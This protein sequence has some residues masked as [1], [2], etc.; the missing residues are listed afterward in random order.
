[1][2]ITKKLLLESQNASP[3][4]VDRPRPK[5]LVN[6]RAISHCIASNRIPSESTS[7]QQE[8]SQLFRDFVWQ[9]K[10]SRSL[11]SQLRREQCT[12]VQARILNIVL[13]GNDLVV[14]A[15][16]DSG[17]T[18]ALLISTIQRHLIEP[19][20]QHGHPSILIIV[21]TRGLALQLEATV[22]EIIGK[23]PWNCQTA[24]GGTNVQIDIQRVRQKCDI[25][26]ATP[27]RLSALLREEGFAQRMRQIRCVIVEEAGKLNRPNQR[28]DLFAI[29]K[30]LPSR[31][32][33]RQTLL[34]A[35][36]IT[37]RFL[38][39]VFLGKEYQHLR[40]SQGYAP[41]H[42]HIQKYLILDS[43]WH[44]PKLA[45]T[46]WD[47]SHA[48]PVNKVIVFFSTART[49]A[50]ASATLSQ[51]D[52]RTPVFELHS[53]TSLAARRRVARE[54]TESRS[55]ILLSSDLT[56][57]GGFEFPGITSVI[58]VG[59][60]ESVSEYLQRFRHATH[61]GLRLLILAPW[62]QR[63]L[64]EKG[65]KN[66]PLEEECMDDN[67]MKQLG[68][69]K[70]KVD[71]AMG[72]VEEKTKVGA[73]QAMLS[74]YAQKQSVMGL[75]AESVLLVVN[76]YAKKTLR[77]KLGV[78]GRDGLPPVSAKAAAMINLPASLKQCELNIE[79]ASD[80]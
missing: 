4:Q 49:V 11:V 66:L 8:T 55:G 73:Y 33:G 2:T 64:A 61:H 34:S 75:S 42:G 70:E 35:T 43:E 51:I 5:I 3:K 9:G 52:I 44:L 21:P 38:I 13:Q 23:S 37:E 27:G 14:E 59:L 76:Q 65:L 71:H 56:I 67:I 19:N 1:M 48:S 32:G 62:E 24:I 53:R 72:S 16:E 12:A 79:R 31:E 50:L 30:L 36:E 26:V 28:R 25:L 74:Y 6:N 20:V 39:D 63:F 7:S 15:N 78:E 47:T 41:S 60:P 58:Q 22:N 40:L 17:R 46:I 68:L 54:F 45:K 77:W 29:S 57:G 18:L 10:L 80:D 69:W